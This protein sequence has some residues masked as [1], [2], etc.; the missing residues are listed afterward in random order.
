MRVLRDT[1]KAVQR[2][3]GIAW[4]ILV[5]LIGYGYARMASLNT[6][7]GALAAVADLITHPTGKKNGR[8]SSNATNK[9]FGEKF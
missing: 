6:R 4:L 2:R 1:T 7:L 8:E 3:A 5:R 9:S